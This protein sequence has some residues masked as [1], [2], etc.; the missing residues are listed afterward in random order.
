MDK[1][2]KETR[3]TTYE[4]NGNI[5]KDIEIITWNQVEML[6]LKSKIIEIKTSLEGFNSSLI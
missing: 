1:D 3:K 5:N 4:K 2:I 6:E